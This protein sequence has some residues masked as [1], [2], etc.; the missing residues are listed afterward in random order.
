MKQIAQTAKILASVFV[1]WTGFSAAAQ[2]PGSGSPTGMDAAMI[3]LFG[4][5]NAFT[6]KANV[7]VL[8]KEKKETTSVPLGFSLLDQKVRVEID[9]TQIMSKQLAEEDVAGMKQMGLAQIISIIRPDKKATYVIYPSQKSFLR[10]PMSKEE[11]DVLEANPKIEKS[12]LGKETIDGHPCTKNKVVVTSSQSKTLEAT[13]WNASDLKDFPLQIETT[14]KETTS[15]IRFK[16]VRF[17]K[18]DPA[19]FEPTAGYTE[20]KDQ[21]DLMVAIAKK[22]V[23]NAPDSNPPK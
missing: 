11:S 18:T 16:D 3:K 1:A 15:I 10:M 5:V 6:A 9:V 4:N 13:T 7:Q 21:M 17:T 12:P 23:N 22:S 19:Q 20:Y 14:D 2:M 8:D